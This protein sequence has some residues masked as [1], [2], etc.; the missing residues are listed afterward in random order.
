MPEEDVCSP[1]APYLLKRKKELKQKLKEKEEE[2]AELAQAVLA[3]RK[4]IVEMQAEIQRRK[5][6]WEVSAIW[7]HV[8]G[9]LGLSRPAFLKLLARTLRG[10]CPPRVFPNWVYV[11]GGG[12]S[13]FFGPG[14]GIVEYSEPRTPLP[15]RGGA[16]RKCLDTLEFVNP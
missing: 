8:A 15:W 12:T 5:E 1:V 3:G 6:A 11:V 7:E 2:N 9:S 16:E 13:G 14:V 4:E 10:F